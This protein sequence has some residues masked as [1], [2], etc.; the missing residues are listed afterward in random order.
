VRRFVIIGQTALASADFSL[1][2]LPSSSGRLDVLLRCVRAALLVSHGLRPNALAYLM[3]RGGL[4]G[5]RTLR[6]GGD[7]AKFLRP[8]E[9]S[10][11]TL[12]KKTLAAC[13]TPTPEVYTELR[14][15]LALRAG[16]LTELLIEVG[17]SPC[18]M[19]HEGAPDLREAIASLTD[20]DAWFFIGD[21]LGF[22]PVA[23]A[24]LDHHGARRVSVGPVSLHSD[25]VVSIVGNEL[26]R[27]FGEPGPA[28]P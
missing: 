17:G 23:L 15:G 8:D 1:E 27:V 14:P 16:D 9:R 22:D 6:I 21:H 28:L 4:A 19:L 3:L 25:D 7:T 2:D 20:D 11:A 13:P 12:V 5:P 26:D 10:L 24:L 18:F